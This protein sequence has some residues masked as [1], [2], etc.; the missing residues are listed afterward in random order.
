MSQL[1]PRNTL[2]SILSCISMVL[3]CGCDRVVQQKSGIGSNGSGSLRVSDSAQPADPYPDEIVSLTR[4]CETQIK[5]SFKQYPGYKIVCISV[6]AER[7]C[8]GFQHKLDLSDTIPANT[9]VRNYNG[10]QLA[11]DKDDVAFLTG[12]KLDYVK[13]PPG[14]FKFDHPRPDTSLLT[15]YRLKAEEAA[16]LRPI[17]EAKAKQI[18]PEKAVADLLSDRRQQA[19]DDLR[20]WWKFNQSEVWSEYASPVRSVERYKLP[21][22]KSITVVFTGS[23][24]DSGRGVDVIGDDGRNRPIFGGHNYIEEQGNYLDVNGDSIP[25]IVS[26][27]LQAS[28]KNRDITATYFVIVPLD[29]E[30]PLL[31]ISFDRRQFSGNSTW[32]WK[33]AKT[34]SGNSDVILEQQVKNK[35][36]ERARFIWSKEKSKYEGPSG[37]SKDGFIAAPGEISSE[38]IDQFFIDATKE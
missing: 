35:W 22:G 9:I 34:K 29:S 30:R 38:E 28:D 24:G 19:Y 31:S 5:E 33:L 36:V 11:I 10:I 32:K 16:R 2:C 26:D 17:E 13:G 12:T 6:A 3:Y 27:V 37:S 25:E 23:E 20:L 21:T 14:G 7:N 15:E 8:T 4:D 18:D 1:L